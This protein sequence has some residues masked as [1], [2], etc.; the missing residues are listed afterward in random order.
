[1]F[2]FSK[3][4]VNLS[5]V[6]S[7]LGYGVTTAVDTK[8]LEDNMLGCLDYDFMVDGF[9]NGFALGVRADYDLVRG[10][11]RLHPA[12]LKLVEILEE[13]VMKGMIIGAFD[14]PPEAVLHIYISSACHPK[15]RQCKRQDDL[16][17]LASSHRICQ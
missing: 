10:K 17:P 1:M 5:F 8:K 3:C 16:Q 4:A 6:T 13:E 14:E 9:T 2:S 12:P 7:F 15:G 11:T